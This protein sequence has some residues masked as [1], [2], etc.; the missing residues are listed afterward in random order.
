MTSKAKTET[1]RL[2]EDIQVEREIKSPGSDT[3]FKYSFVENPFF[4][5]ELIATYYINNK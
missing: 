2:K 5:N 4:S 3:R 1:R